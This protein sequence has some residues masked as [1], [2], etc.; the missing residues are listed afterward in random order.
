MGVVADGP[1]A[2]PARAQSAAACSLNRLTAS[3]TASPR[4]P[5]LREV[6]QFVE[7]LAESHPA[8]PLAG[9]GELVHGDRALDVTADDPVTE[10]P[11][12][13]DEKAPALGGTHPRAGA[14]GQSQ[15]RPRHATVLDHQPFGAGLQQQRAT[16]PA[17]DLAAPDIFRAHATLL[18][19]WDEPF[20]KNR[21]QFREQALGPDPPVGIIITTT[22]V[23]SPDEV[24]SGSGPPVP[25]W[26]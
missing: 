4:Y 21:I 19:P 26:R 3:R 7:V 18:R 15:L 1:G 6:G 16:A 25:R 13:A 2:G 12:V 5:H 23:S 8:T 22:E 14:I 24:F 9:Q 10:D 11:G 17:D 20:Q